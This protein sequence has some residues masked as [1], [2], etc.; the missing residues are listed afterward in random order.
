[1]LYDDIVAVRSILLSSMNHFSKVW[2]LKG[3]WEPLHL[4]PVRCMGGQGIPKVWLVSEVRAVL[5]RTVPFILW[6][7]CL[8]VS[9][10][11]EPQLR[12]NGKLSFKAQPAMVGRAE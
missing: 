8:V 4:R 7:L 10:S 5:L 6:G 11:I 1:M 2:N 9:A 3:S 12:L